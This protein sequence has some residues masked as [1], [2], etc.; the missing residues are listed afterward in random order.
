M[1]KVHAFGN[2]S[3]KSELRYQRNEEQIKFGEC[4]LPSS[5]VSS[6]IPSP[7]VLY[8]YETW[9]REEHS[10]RVS[11][12]KVQRRMIE[13]KRREF[14]EDGKNRIMRSFQICALHRILLG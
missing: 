1:F 14:R 12:N 8:G 2:K 13:P 10:L 3:D 7:V 6:A 4:F 11:E 9:S 5:S